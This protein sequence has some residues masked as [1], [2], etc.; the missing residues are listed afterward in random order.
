MLIARKPSTP[1]SCRLKRDARSATATAP[2]SPNTA[3]EA[4]AVNTFGSSASA[5]SEPPSIDTA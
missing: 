4:P 1:E 5:P 3:P 2:P